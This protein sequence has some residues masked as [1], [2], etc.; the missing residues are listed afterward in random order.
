MNIEDV[1]K[2]MNRQVTYKGADHWQLNACILRKNE[3]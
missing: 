1:K 3:K 2:Y